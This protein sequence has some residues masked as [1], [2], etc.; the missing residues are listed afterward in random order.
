MSGIFAIFKLEL[1]FLGTIILIWHAK[2][3]RAEAVWYSVPMIAVPQTYEQEIISHR[4]H[5]Q[6]AGIMILPEEVTA[7]RL[8]KTAQKILSDRS[9]VVNSARLGNACRAAG[10]AKRAVDE[11]LRY[12]HNI[13]N[14]VSLCLRKDAL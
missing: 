9:F 1:Y 8:Q 7:E 3:A 6:G 12:V 5:K 11:I 4:I 13:R 2:Y 10:G 14:P